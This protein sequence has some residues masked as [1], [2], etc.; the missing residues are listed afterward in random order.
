MGEKLRP[1]ENYGV[2]L[3]IYWVISDKLLEENISP[4]GRKLDIYHAISYINL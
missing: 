3:I 1:P 2:W 4:E